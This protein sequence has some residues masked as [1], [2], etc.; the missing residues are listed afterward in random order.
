[1]EVRE[2]FTSA[3][4]SAH[5]FAS[6]LDRRVKPFA[7]PRDHFSNPFGYVVEDELDSEP[8]E[9]VERA[10][11]RARAIRAGS[12]VWGNRAGRGDMDEV[13]EPRPVTC[14]GAGWERDGERRS[15]DAPAPGCDDSIMGVSPLYVLCYRTRFGGVGGLFGQSADSTIENSAG[16]S[17]HAPSVAAPPFKLLN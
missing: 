7:F 11:C 14:L 12:K 6:R 15:R 8:Q 2:R 16:W 10:P 13:E 5:S 3:S 9:V 4:V 17:L 1:M